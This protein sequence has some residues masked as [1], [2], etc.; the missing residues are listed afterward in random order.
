[1][2]QQQGLIKQ[3]TAVSIPQSYMTVE[4]MIQQ[5]N[6][7]Q[8]VMQKIMKSGEHYGVIPGCG[9]KPAL[10]KPGAEKLCMT[11]RLS[12]KF[13]VNV[14][15]LPNGHHQVDVRFI[16]TNIDT[17]LFLGEGVGSCSTMESKWRFRKAEAKCPECGK[18]TIIRGKQEYGGGWL[19]YRKKGGCGAKFKDGDPRIENQDMGRV[20]YDNPADYWN[21]CLKM[22]KKRA[23]VDATLTVT[24]AS[25][26]FTQDIDDSPELYGGK[27]LIQDA[28]EVQH[29]DV[30][31]DLET[32]N[33][34][35]NTEEDEI[36][37]KRMERLQAIELWLLEMAHGEEAAFNALL[38]ECSKYTPRGGEQGKD[39]KWI[40]DID[41]LGKVSDKYLNTVYGRTKVT[42]E[43]WK[44][45][46]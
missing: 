15:D 43:E 36:A 6:L 16:M 26:I 11:F 14:Q 39:D 32:R 30:F 40:H 18:E 21:T 45:G 33:V 28:V 13:E 25:D 34:N 31:H 5:V 10:L 35:N 38:K 20:E 4:D 37:K 12:P 8:Q 42:Y 7:I 17:G 1:M 2:E 19:C 41:A 23:L 22:A 24:A 27:P 46:K 29:E 3:Q 44:K 9:D